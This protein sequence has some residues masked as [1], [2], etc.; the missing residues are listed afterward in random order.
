M[1]MLLEISHFLALNFN[2]LYIIVVVGQ[3]ILIL[4]S[5]D[6][7]HENSDAGNLSMPEKP[8]IIIMHVQKRIVMPSIIRT[9]F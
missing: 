6:P 7:K 2:I 5:T 9:I 8:I 4:L 1:W 3:I